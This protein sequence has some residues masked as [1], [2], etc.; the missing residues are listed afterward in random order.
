M[1]HVGRILWSG[2]NFA[3]RTVGGVHRSVDA[4]DKGVGDLR[5]TSFELYTADGK[6][7][8]NV[9]IFSDSVA[10]LTVSTCGAK[11][12]QPESTKPKTILSHISPLMDLSSASVR[13]GSVRQSRRHAAACTFGNVDGV[14]YGRLPKQCCAL[15]KLLTPNAKKPKKKGK[16]KESLS[17]MLRAPPRLS[18]WLRDAGTPWSGHRTLR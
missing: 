11:R 1:Y 2:A 9:L 4:S 6:H 16:E 5:N 13:I 15:D 17:L 3:A 12:S 7:G 18:V 10:Y 8:N 14:D